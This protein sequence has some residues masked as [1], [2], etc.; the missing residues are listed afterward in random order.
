MQVQPESQNNNTDGN[1]LP[2]RY[3][4]N[5]CEPGET[6]TMA[7]V[8]EAET[9]FMAISAGDIVNPG[10]WPTSQAPLR[11]YRVTSVEHMIYSNGVHQTHLV[12]VYT[13]DVEGTLELRFP[14]K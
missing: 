5:I 3:V 1:P 10:L 2:V 6:G 12:V 13:E 14:K 11:V 8:F 4:L 7:A 9:P